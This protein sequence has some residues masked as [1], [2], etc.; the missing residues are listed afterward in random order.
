MTLARHGHRFQPDTSGLEG[1]DRGQRAARG[2]NPPPGSPPERASRPPTEDGAV[3]SRKGKRPWR[4][5][6]VSNP[7]YFG[8]TSPRVTKHGLSTTRARGYF[9]SEAK[10]ASRNLRTV[11]RPRR[12][13]EL[14]GPLV[15]TATGALRAH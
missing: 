9:I 7:L 4:W 13:R 5:I 10:D 15:L 1:R 3:C 6:P 8:P 11:T 12:T 14:L 2:T